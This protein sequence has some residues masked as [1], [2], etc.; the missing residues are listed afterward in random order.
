MVKCIQCWFDLPDVAFSVVV[1]SRAIRSQTKCRGYLQSSFKWF[2]SHAEDNW[3]FLPWFMSCDYK[4]F[5]VK[6]SSDTSTSLVVFFCY[7]GPVRFFVGTEGFIRNCWLFSNVQLLLS[8]QDT[9]DF[10]LLSFRQA[11]SLIIAMFTWQNRSSKLRYL[12]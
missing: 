5:N 4:L 7:V 11:A 9:Y 2:P 8:I 1:G 3:P 10:L 6:Q 12:S